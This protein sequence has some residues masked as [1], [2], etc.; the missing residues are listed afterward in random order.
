MAA[1][2]SGAGT[3]L[4]QAVTD[5][6]FDT[7]AASGVDLQV[8]P[9]NA[10]ARRVYLREG[11]VSGGLDEPE[12]ERMILTREAWTALPRRAAP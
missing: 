2:G 4:L 10:R 9:D 6:L 1:P 11:L 5:W 12:H 3:R 7:T 8:R